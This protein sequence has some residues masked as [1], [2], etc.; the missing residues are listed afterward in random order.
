MVASVADFQQRFP[1]F[2]EVDDVVVQLYLDD[3]ALIMSSEGKWLKFYDTAQVYYAAHFLAVAEHTETGD[4]GALA[5]IKKQDV[6]DVLIESAVS[7]VSPSADELL[8]T[9]YGKRVLFYRKICFS[10]IRGV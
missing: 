2:C 9:A 7:E 1:E 8:S 5:P 6:D 3:V 4:T 10:G